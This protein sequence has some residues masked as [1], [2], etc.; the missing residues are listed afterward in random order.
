MKKNHNLIVLF[1]ALIPFFACKDVIF[2]PTQGAISGIVTDNNGVPL[3][4]VEVSATFSAPV[5]A[6]G[7]PSFP[8]TLTTTT[9]A[10]GY[11]Q[12]ME[13]WDVVTLN[14]A[15]PGFAGFSTYV[16]LEKNSHPVE[17]IVLLG[18]PT[19][20]E[21]HLSKTELST[22]SD[23]LTAT[24]RIEDKFNEQ[25]QGYSGNLLLQK[26][27]LTQIIA[28]G[29]VTA[30]SLE[31]ILIEVRLISGGLPAGNYA[32]IAEVQDPDGNTHQMD[33]GKTIMVQ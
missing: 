22:T 14:V 8:T 15:Y 26:N 12:L 29:V 31:H 7:Q 17:N 20:L 18:S 2:I 30:Q 6:V 3:A 28:N 10:T 27:G 25:A 11:F 32:V 21:V 24:L 23:T 4:G 1:L 33:T 13:L 16:D 5:Q 19:I 9:D